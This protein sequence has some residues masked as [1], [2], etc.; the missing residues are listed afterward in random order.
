M[1]SSI[2][3]FLFPSSPFFSPSIFPSISSDLVRSTTRFP[4]RPNVFTSSASVVSTSFCSSTVVLFPSYTVSFIYSSN[5]FFQ[6]PSFLSIGFCISAHKRLTIFLYRFVSFWKNFNV[7]TTVSCR[8]FD[9]VN[10]Q[11]SEMTLFVVSFMPASRLSFG[12]I[13]HVV[14]GLITRFTTISL[15]S[16]F[17]SVFRLHSAVRL[18]NQHGHSW[19]R[20]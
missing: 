5:T 9:P 13:V 17:V 11:T 8:P 16:V 19:F 1:F 7:S 2:L 14:S 3:G 18:L 4:F 20:Q 10:Q 12:D 15:W 6:F